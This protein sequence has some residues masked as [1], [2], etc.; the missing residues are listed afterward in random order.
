MLICNPSKL[1]LFNTSILTA[2]GTFTYHHLSLDEARELV[3]EFQRDGKSI[4]SA[5]GHQST[6]DFISTLLGYHVQGNRI[7][8][9]QTT[10]DLALIFKPN[11]RLADGKIL[12]REEIEEFGYEF[13]LLTRTS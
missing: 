12:T 11:R 4:E 8:L 2:Y 10:D 5:I 1:I 13:G 9:E 6:A 3:Q 7:E